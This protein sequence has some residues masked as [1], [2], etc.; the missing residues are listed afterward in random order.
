MRTKIHVHVGTGELTNICTATQINKNK[1]KLILYPHC[2]ILKVGNW[3][4]LNIYLWE[5]EFIMVI[6]YMAISEILKEKIVR[7]FE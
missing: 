5:K 2:I 6:C 3:P 7:V 4:N 1:I